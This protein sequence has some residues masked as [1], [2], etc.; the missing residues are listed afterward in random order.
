MNYSD[1][2]EMAFLEIKRLPAYNDDEGRVVLLN[3]NSE[4]LDDFAYDESMH[5]SQLV[6]DEGVALERINPNKE[7]NSKSNWTSASQ[8]SNFGTPGMQNSSYDID[9]VEVNEIGFKSK[10]FT[11]DNDGVDDRLVIYFNLE[12]SGYVANIRIY[13]SRGMEIRRLASN[14]TLSTND[15]M[16]WDGLLGNKERAPF[17]I[18]I[19][20]FELFH[21][22][23][24][25][26]VYKKTCVL[27]G[28]FK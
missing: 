12:K 1:R 15:E 13:N 7:T 10:I 8:T 23:G 5:F 26:K 25:V 3:S 18:Y 21:P 27:G 9:N 14:M 4:Q 16:F 20:Y 11:P 6:S 17:G 28:K 19:V 24:E 2:D 22:D